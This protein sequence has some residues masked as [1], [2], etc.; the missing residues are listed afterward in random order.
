MLTWLSDFDDFAT[1]GLEGSHSACWLC[2][3]AARSSRL[4]VTFG[5]RR[6]QDVSCSVLQGRHD[7]TAARRRSMF[8]CCRTKLVRCHMQSAA[9]VSR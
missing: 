4:C 5:Q 3:P 1:V 8:A 2:V 6:Y 7:E 9:G